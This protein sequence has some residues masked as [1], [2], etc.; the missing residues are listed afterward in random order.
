[1]KPLSPFSQL[2]VEKIWRKRPCYGAGLTSLE[3]S[4]LYCRLGERSRWTTCPLYMCRLTLWNAKKLQ[5]SKERQKMRG[6]WMPISV[7]LY[8]WY[9][10]AK[11]SSTCPATVHE[12]RDATGSTNVSGAVRQSWQSTQNQS[13]CCFRMYDHS[14]TPFRSHGLA[15]EDQIMWARINCLIDS[16]ADQPYALEIR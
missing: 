4:T 11:W 1:M 10:I 16:I 8:V 7:F 12:F 2:R 13:Y 3:M 9:L 6:W 15:L 14:C 5:Q